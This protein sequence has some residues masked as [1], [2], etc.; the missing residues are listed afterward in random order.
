MKTKNNLSLIWISVLI[1]SSFACKFIVPDPSETPPAGEIIYQTNQDGNFELYSIDIRSGA[2]FRL[3]NNSANDMSPT[4]IAAK[5]QIGFISDR[6]NGL[7][8]YVMDTLGENIKSIISE[9]GTAVEYPDWS[10]D[11]EFI[12]ASLVE[13]CLDP[14]K[15]CVYDIYVMNADGTNFKNLTNTPESEWVPAWSPDGEQ[16][17]FSSDRDGDSEIYVMNRDGSHLV[18]LTKN[19]G[20]DGRPRWSIDGTRFAFETDRDGGDWDIYTM[21]TDGT[22]PSPI[23]NNVS[24]DISESWS[25]DGNWLVYVSNS[26]GDNEIFIIDS[27]GQNQRQLTHNSYN[28]I[29][30][31]WIP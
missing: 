23:T 28:D 27:N 13:E 18:Q 26:D 4:F 17:A 3:T 25:P 24:N 14:A 6:Q 19:S 2:T 15:K 30:P 5:N 29:G 11:G 31:I 8:L 9:K 12:T 16:L 7:H 20:Y 1:F 10:P 21:N 22:D